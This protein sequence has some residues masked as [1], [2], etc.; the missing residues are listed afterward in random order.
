MSN[1]IIQGTNI[2]LRPITEAD[3]SMVLAWRN[4]DSVVSNYYYRTPISEEEHLN[5]IRNKVDKGEVY[6]YIVHASEND[7]PVGCVYLQ[8]IDEK[9]LTG[10]TGVFFSEDAPAGKGLATEAVKLIGEKAGF[11]MLGLLHL[12]AK[13]ME[14]N[15]A[16]RRVHEKQ[17]TDLSGE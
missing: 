1:E 16:S 3:T 7:A 2:Y 10:E 11:E 13:V 12:I 9:T 8:H 17:D 6:Q 4:S 14:K 5:W 15:T